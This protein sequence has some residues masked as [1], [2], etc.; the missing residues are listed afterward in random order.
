MYNEEVFS[1]YTP[2]EQKQDKKHENDLMETT[3]HS[4]FFNLIHGLH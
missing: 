3:P 2:V 4:I 1:E